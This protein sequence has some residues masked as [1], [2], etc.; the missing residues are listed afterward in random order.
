MS[1]TIWR[2]AYPAD[3]YVLML[4]IPATAALRRAADEK[5]NV[6]LWDGNDVARKLKN[7]PAIVEDFFGTSW[8]E[9]F[10]G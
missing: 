1:S 3:H 7:Y 9:A 6:F 10:C 2:V 8:W 5:T 4:S